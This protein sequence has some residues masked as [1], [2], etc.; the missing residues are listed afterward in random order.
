MNIKAKDIFAILIVMFI[1]SM[2][3]FAF[4]YPPQARALPIYVGAITIF[5]LVIQL[6]M[7]TVPYFGKRLAFLKHTEIQFIKVDMNEG[8]KQEDKEEDSKRTSKEIRI[9]IWLLFL[10]ILLYFLDYVLA[11]AL[12]LL[13]FLRIEAKAKWLT[14]LLVTIL[15]T[16]GIYLLF[17]I[18]LKFIMI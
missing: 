16:G 10:G 9:I 14:N 18:A 8:S 7:D 1:G 11:I 15:F 2:V 17:R 13:L 5:L 12:F 4:Q 6:L 3:F